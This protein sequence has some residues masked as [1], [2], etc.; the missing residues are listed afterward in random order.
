MFVLRN[1]EP[2]IDYSVLIKVRYYDTQYAMLG[3][4]FAFKFDDYLDSD[5]LLDLHDNI[6]QRLNVLFDNY[7]LSGDDINQFY[8][9]FR[10]VNW[11]E[12]EHLKIDSSK[13]KLT[14]HEYNVLK[15]VSRYFPVTFDPVH[16]GVPLEVKYDANKVICVLALSDDAYKKGYTDF[17]INYNKK[18]SVLPNRIRVPDFNSNVLFYQK[19]LSNSDIIMAVEKINDKQWKK[20]VFSL[21]GMFISSVV[22]TLMECDK[23][24]SILVKRDF[25]S[26]THYILNNEIIFSKKIFNFPIIK[27]DKQLTTNKIVENFRIGVIDIENYTNSF[28]LGRAYAIGFYTHLDLKPVTFYIDKDTL[29]SYTLIMN[30]INELL[31]PRYKDI[32]FYAHN[33]GKFDFTFIVK[34]VLEYNNKNKSADDYNIVEPP[35]TRNDVILKKTIKRV[36]GSKTSSISITDSFAILT[37][38][39]KS[40]SLKYEVDVVKGDF[41]HDFASENTLFYKGVTP[42]IVHYNSISKQDYKLLYK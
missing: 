34:A 20:W 5:N 9:Y 2:K 39:L 25:G 16:Y 26:N 41:P 19:K 37:D 1:L 11:E 17:M 29:D 33:F 14:R 32:T 4:Q 15:K 23:N 3:N 35:V 21:N 30:C 18:N 27:K 40:L 28:K 38:N 7:S 13:M 12:I 36:Q 10:K 22:D 6:Y 24:N 8:L 42:N 31:K